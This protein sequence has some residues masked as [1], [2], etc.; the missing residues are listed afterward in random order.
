MDDGN[1]KQL[2]SSFPDHMG[3]LS[4]DHACMHAP[5]LAWPDQWIGLLA[6]YVGGPALPCWHTLALTSLAAMYSII[7]SALVCFFHDLLY[8]A[9]PL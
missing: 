1:K 8:S 5:C 7:A 3:G 2:S 9:F 4:W 6:W